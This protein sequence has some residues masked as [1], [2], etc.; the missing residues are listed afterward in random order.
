MIRT[1]TGLA[2]L[3]LIVVVILAVLKVI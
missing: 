3:C 1:L 2:F